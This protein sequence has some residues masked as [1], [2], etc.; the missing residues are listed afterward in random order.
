MPPH[1]TIPCA[2]MITGCESPSEGLPYA[3]PRPSTH[4]WRHRSR[5]YG[6]CARALRQEKEGGVLLHGRQLVFSVS[7]GAEVVS[8][9]GGNAASS[10]SLPASPEAYDLTFRRDAPQICGQGGV[11]WTFART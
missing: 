2:D 7:R 11:R 10:R 8:S 3:R 5:A 1:R 6:D 9:T 4:R